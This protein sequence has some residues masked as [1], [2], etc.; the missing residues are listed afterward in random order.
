LKCTVVFDTT[1]DTH[2][3]KYEFLILLQRVLVVLVLYTLSMLLGYLD[4]ESGVIDDDV[5]ST[6]S[7]LLYNTLL[8]ETN[9][10]C[11]FLG[12]TR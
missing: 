1:C 3:V 6:R 2:C 8:S 9:C 11:R 7:A 5:L 4:A 12:A 10:L